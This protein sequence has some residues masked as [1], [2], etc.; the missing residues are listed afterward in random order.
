MT[1]P[2]FASSGGGAP[3][4]GFG[5]GVAFVGVG[6]AGGN[7][8]RV[9]AAVDDDAAILAEAEA[10]ETIATSRTSRTRPSPTRRTRPST[11]N[12]NRTRIGAPMDR[13]SARERFDSPWTRGPR[14]VAPRPSAWWCTTRASPRPSSPPP[15]RRPRS[16]WARRART[17]STCLAKKAAR[18]GPASSQ[19]AR[20]VGIASAGFARR[21][22]DHFGWTERTPRSP[23][24]RAKSRTPRRPRRRD[25]NQARG[26]APRPLAI[27]RRRGGEDMYVLAREVVVL[28]AVGVTGFGG[29]HALPVTLRG[30][31]RG[32]GPAVVLL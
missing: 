9:V 25:A 1:F 8:R 7:A 13:R 24:P 18:A 12:R 6:F 20:F 27:R 30:G 28:A 17:S 32:R 19:V 10:F 15:R 21:S 14:A 4:V 3:G 2:G 23:S 5:G 16:R 26:F 31:G 22:A 11:R 29:A